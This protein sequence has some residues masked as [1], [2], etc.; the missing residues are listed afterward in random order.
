MA[1]FYGALESTS[2]RVKDRDAWL[3]DPDVQK[4]KGHAEGDGFFEEEKDGYWA[5]GWYGQYPSPVLSEWDDESDEEKNLD[6]TEVIQRHIRPGDVCQIGV[7]GSEK[8]R[9]IGGILC[10]VSSQGIIS[11]DGET[12]WQDKLTMDSF[13]EKMNKLHDEVVNTFGDD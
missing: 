13:H 6:I 10:W 1:D 4:I 8:L 7:S 3:A 11:F 2:F 9:Y 12:C 5:F